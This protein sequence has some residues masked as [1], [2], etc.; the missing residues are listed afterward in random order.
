MPETTTPSAAPTYPY[1]PLG[2]GAPGYAYDPALAASL[3]RDRQVY[4][5]DLD[6]LYTLNKD[7]R[8]AAV[9]T[10]GALEKELYAT[11]GVMQSVLAEKEQTEDTLM[12]V[13]EA[14]ETLKRQFELALCTSVAER[15]EYETTVENLHNQMDQQRQAAASKLGSTVEQ[16]ETK[17]AVLTSEYETRLATTVERYESKIA[18]LKEEHK[19]ALVNTTADHDTKYAM[20]VEKYETK[21]NITIAEH[22]SKRRE[23]SSALSEAQAI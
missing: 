4:E 2:V 15:K 3:V 18:A 23:L 8:D 7:E 11:K 22:E 13:K 9:S 20:C 14:G 5:R 19:S 10:Q 16:F 1:G 17:I 21:L 6:R 12:Q